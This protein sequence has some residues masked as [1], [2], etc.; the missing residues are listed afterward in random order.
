[1][2]KHFLTVVSLACAAALGLAFLPSPAA[3]QDQGYFTYVSEWAVPRAEWAAFEKQEAASHAALQKLVADG[4]LVA[5]GDEATRVHTEDGYTHA[6][7]FT[8]SSRANLLKALE[9]QWA[10]ASNAAYVSTTKHRDLFL[11][12]LAHGG[13]TSSETTGYIRVTFWQ[14]KP[15]AEDAL[16]AHV[17]KY[18]K[19]TLD[20]DV[21]SGTLLMYNFDKEDVHTDEAGGYDLALVFPNGEAMDKFFADLEAGEK[22]NP[23]VG[24][25]LDSLTVAKEHRDDLGRVTAYGH[26]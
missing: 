7:W 15:G 8:A 20:A 12:T 6:D 1:M 5:W 2:L 13:K 26:K 25:V 14:A 4:T 19:P 3:A 24:E 16:E 10:G 9:V 11:N 17:M 22:Q 21:E 23:S 18:L